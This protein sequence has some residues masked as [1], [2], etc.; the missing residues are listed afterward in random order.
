MASYVREALHDLI[1]RQACGLGLHSIS[2]TAWSLIFDE[3][4]TKRATTV[5]VTREL[6]D[7][8]L[9]VLSSVE[10]NNASASGSAIGLVLDFGLL[11]LS[12]GGE[13]LDQVLVACGPRKLLK[14]QQTVKKTI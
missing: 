6:F 3:A 13:E 12:D 7:S 4:Q 10:A 14:R 9:R 8:S 11:D 1:L 5:L 2:A